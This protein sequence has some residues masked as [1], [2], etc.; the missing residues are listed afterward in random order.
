MTTP[1]PGPWPPPPPG[2]GQQ[3]PAWGPQPPWEPPP[4][5][6]GNRGKWILG[7]IALVVVIGLTVVATLLVTRGGSGSGEPTASA[8]PS[9]SADTSD[10]AS[11]DDR[12]PVGIITEDPTCA[13][14]GPIAAAF[15]QGQNN[16]WERRD[17]ALTEGEWTSDQRKQYAAVASVLRDTADRSMA[18]AS[19]TPH[20]V[21][22]ELYEQFIAY[23]RA[24]AAR[25]ETYTPDADHLVRV[26]ISIASSLN[27][28]CDAIAYG[29]AGARSP[30]I[31]RAA[32]PIGPL[33]E[34]NLASPSVFLD[35]PNAMCAPWLEAAQRFVAE[36]TDWRAVDPNVPAVDLSPDQRET[37]ARAS[38][39]MFSFADET[40]RL[41]LQTGNAVWQDI[42]TLSAQYRRAYASALMTY[43]PADNFLQ[44]AASYLAGSV[45]EACRA[46]GA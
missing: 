44:I 3:P 30:L 19:E 36:T 39:L 8:P 5:R 46:V 34:I 33:S 2:P 6:G 4:Q 42:A 24:Y 1:P 9:T 26:S 10:I 38:T 11:A 29:A 27:A 25:V 35:S 41:A 17:P 7:G 16:G 22:R 18:L 31:A 21:M 20:R 40:Q 32:P 14:W 12:G 43:A 45:T 28:I 15:A 37:N 23:N 13:A